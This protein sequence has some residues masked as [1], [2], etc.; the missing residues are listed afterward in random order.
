MISFYPTTLLALL[1]CIFTTLPV[2]VLAQDTIHGTYVKVEDFGFS[3]NPVSSFGGAPGELVD[4][5]LE[6]R[7]GSRCVIPSWIKCPNNP[8]KCHPPGSECCGMLYYYWPETHHCCADGSGSCRLGLNC[9]PKNCCPP[10][11]RCGLDGSCSTRAPSTRTQ[12]S[13]SK[14]TSSSTSPTKSQSKTTRPTETRCATSNRPRQAPPAAQPTVRM[15]FREKFMQVSDGKGGLKRVCIDNREMM[16]SMCDGMKDYNGCI[17]EEMQLN[18]EPDKK[19]RGDNRGKKCPPNFCKSENVDCDPANPSMA[20]NQYHQF[21]DFSASQLSKNHRF[22]L[23]CDE[24]PFANSKQ[25]G[26]TGRGTSICVPAWQQ[27]IQGGHLS[28]IGKRASGPDRAYV[29]ELVGWDCASRR[30][31]SG[32]SKNC[33]G[34]A[35]REIETTNSRDV[36]GEDL[37]TDFEE[38]GENYLLLYIGDLPAGEYTYDLN[39]SSGSF[40]EVSIIDKLGEQY[41]AIPGFNAQNGRQTISFSLTDGASGLALM[42]ITRDTNISMAYNAT[43]LTGADAVPKNN[44]AAGGFLGLLRGDWNGGLLLVFPTAVAFGMAVVWM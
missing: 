24:F 10:E 3:L 25:G 32:V 7:Q 6:K 35:K 22:Q 20:C 28:G 44:S 27:N 31:K 23:T 40:S 41:A 34:N 13:T 8:T 2:L 43:G 36:A 9:C 14:S 12:P 5:V 37:W 17:S 18:Y 19:A 29:L 33:R 26:D 30:P 21:I 4:A 15:R 42:G 11:G 38:P 1:C 39:L 16:N